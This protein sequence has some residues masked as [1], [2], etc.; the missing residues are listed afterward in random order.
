M[1]TIRKVLIALPNAQWSGTR[2]FNIHPYAACIL[3]SVLRDRYEV[4]I[5]DANL[6]NLTLEESVSRILEFSPDVVGISSMSIEYAQSC[7]QLAK[8]LKER[9][10]KT[11]TVMGG[12]YPTLLPEVAA[13]DENIDY[14]VLSEGERRFPELLDAL[15]EGCS[16][17][18]M[19][20]IAFLEKGR[21]R[22][23]PQRSFIEDL[24]SVPFP[25]YDLV[26]FHGYADR[27]NRYSLYNNP[28]HLPYGVIMSSR[29]CPFHCVFCSSNHIHG[30]KCRMRSAQNV[31]EEI[32][33]LVRE[34]GVKEI[35]FLDDN[36][37]LDRKRFVEILN[38]LRDRNYDLRWK[39]TNI[40][41]FSLDDDLLDLMKATQCYQVTLPI[42]SGNEEVLRNIIRK[43]L[44]LKKAVKVIES[45]KKRGFEVA[46]LFVIG[47]PGETWDQ[48]LETVNFADSID[49]DWVVF[50]IA[51]P[52]PKTELYE[53]AKRMGY[54]EP[55]F[56][57]SDFRFFGFGH[58]S[59][60][61]DEFT[62]Q[63]LQM[64]RAIEW[65]RIN[66]R[67]EEKRKKI[68]LMNSISLEEVRLWRT[69]T[70][71]NTGGYV[72]YEEGDE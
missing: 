60:T 22:I 4:R 17:E 13:Q 65:D 30:R 44:N 21:V 46:C 29:G 53:I 40:P 56:N 70:R 34:R 68:A 25:A 39:A 18:D 10:E 28:R 41:A 14:V 12:A 64:L 58:G 24:D 50:S 54:L 66:F 45:A 35:I 37:L 1:V 47:L 6:E 62:P 67:T 8:L 3:A 59:I 57:F 15:Q 69:S 19:D 52:L 33:L 55:D 51:T 72:K 20:G 26:D 36:L 2:Q 23:N 43:P 49:V 7:H 63:E 27:H 71:R 5:L 11:I 31:L 16:L 48:I 9:S 42:E 38:G 32:D 61:T